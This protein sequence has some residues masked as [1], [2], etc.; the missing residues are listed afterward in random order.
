VSL[1]GLRMIQMRSIRPWAI[2]IAIEATASV[3][4]ASSR[5]RVLPSAHGGDVKSQIGFQ[6][7]QAEQVAGDRLGAFD[8]FDGR[9]DEPAVIGDGRGIRI[10]VSMRDARAPVSST[11]LNTEMTRA[12]SPAEM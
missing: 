10:E 5:Q 6:L 12:C 2:A 11:A 3:C 7:A 8:R 9:A 1:P 4:P